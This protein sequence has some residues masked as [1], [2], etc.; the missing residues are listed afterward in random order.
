MISEISKNSINYVAGYLSAIPGIKHGTYTLYANVPVKA[1]NRSDTG[2]S[3]L[4]KK[5][6]FNGNSDATLDLVLCHGED[7]LMSIMLNNTVNTRDMLDNTLKGMPYV[8]I[9]A[10][11]VLGK[12]MKDVGSFINSSLSRLERDP[13][14][15]YLKYSLSGI[16]PLKAVCNDIE[17]TN[18][19]PLYELLIENGRNTYFGDL[20]GVFFR[21]EINPQTEAV[22]SFPVIAQ[23]NQSDLKLDLYSEH[24]S[25]DGK[26]PFHRKIDFLYRK[27]PS[28]PEAAEYAE[29]ELNVLLDTSLKEIFRGSQSWFENLKEDVNKIKNHA[30]EYGLSCKE[31]DLESYRDLMEFLYSYISECEDNDGVSHE[32]ASSLGNNV[33]TDLT[34]A[35]YKPYA[36]SDFDDE[37]EREPAPKT[38]SLKERIKRLVPDTNYPILNVPIGGYF[39]AASKLL[40]CSYPYVL[41]KN[42]MEQDISVYAN[43][44]LGIPEPEDSF[45]GAIMGLM[46]SQRIESES[47][48]FSL[49]YNLFVNPIANRNFKTKEC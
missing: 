34:C 40:G 5:D 20:C 4:R 41:Y 24:I 29:K 18:G 37:P 10:S 43:F 22:T 15:V 35:L 28:S 2:K 1:V 9:G 36:P 46:R 31:T 45:I 48:K 13:K 38:M 23:R 42:K 17:L 14:N 39:Y 6:F 11:E 7:V 47:E 27:L 32:Y 3:P 16:S 8:S 49:L 44:Q 30:N 26:I 19:K 25:A 12:K 33:L 21:Y